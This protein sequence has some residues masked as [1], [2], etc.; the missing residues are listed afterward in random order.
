MSMIRFLKALALIVA[1]ST[2]VSCNSDDE[3]PTDGSSRLVLTFDP[4]YQGEVL[5]LGDRFSNPHNYSVEITD[6]KFYISDIEAIRE[7]GSVQQ[8][9]EVELL[10]IRSNKRSVSFDVSPGSYS[11]IRFSLG[12]PVELNGTD[13]EDNNIAIYDVNHPL[14]ENNGMYWTWESGYRFF[15]LEGRFD[16]TITEAPT[17]PQLF[18][19]HSGR[20]TLYRELP[21]FQYAFNLPAGSTQLVE[22][23]I[24]LDK[25]FVGASDVV[26]LQWDTQFHGSF[27]QMDLGIRFANNSAG[28][29]YRVE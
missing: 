18:S 19:F 7:D 24:D 3:E 13:N 12:V 1:F 6:M 11:S 21:A 5:G 26:D 20:D 2:I 8:L 23:G 29:I 9:S 16:T 15:V 28:A 22:F 25:I 17:L 27:S 14:S 10:D 4:R